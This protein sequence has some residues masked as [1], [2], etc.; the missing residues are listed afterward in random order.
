VDFSDFAEK[1]N[2]RCLLNIHHFALAVVG[3]RRPEM[4]LLFHVARLQTIGV[5]QGVAMDSLVLKFHHALPFYAVQA[6]HP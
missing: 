2:R 6:G 4:S 1:P 5:W 3:G